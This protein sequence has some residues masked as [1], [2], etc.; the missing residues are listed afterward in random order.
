LLNIHKIAAINCECDVS[1]VC[2]HA[3]K[4]L[5]FCA[6]LSDIVRYRETS[7]DELN[8]LKCAL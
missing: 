2:A 7:L 4:R 3:Y 6:V 1:I 5:S 8:N